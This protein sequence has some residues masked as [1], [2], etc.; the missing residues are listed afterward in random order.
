MLLLPRFPEECFMIFHSFDRYRSQPKGNWRDENVPGSGQL[1]DLGTHLIDQ[2]VS[3]FG[4]PQKVTGFTQNIRLLGNPSVDDAVSDL[5][6][7]YT[8]Q[9]MNVFDLYFRFL[10]SLPSIFITPLIHNESMH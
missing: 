6:C 8:E 1:Y 5:T 4:R 10:H 7:T 2:V 9:L 3:L